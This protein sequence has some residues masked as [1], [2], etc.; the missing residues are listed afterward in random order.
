MIAARAASY[1]AG[2][3]SHRPSSAP[4]ALGA[5]P[6]HPVCR[7]LLREAS[8]SRRSSSTDDD[9]ASCRDPVT[10]AA[11]RHRRRSARRSRRTRSADERQEQRG[12]VA[13]EVQPTDA[14]Q[15]ADHSRSS[16]PVRWMNTACSVGDST[17][18]SR[19]S[20]PAVLDLAAARA[21]RA[22]RSST[23]FDHHVAVSASTSNRLFTASAPPASH[24]QVTRHDPF[25]EP[26]VVLEQFIERAVGDHPCRD[27]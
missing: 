17:C 22:P 27:R 13:L 21:D 9:H 10:A 14:D 26:T 25:G 4:C 7:D 15:C 19:T 16:R 5:G 11:D 8:I 18:R 6:P 23:C 2:S 3:G 24:L 12:P 20:P 1:G